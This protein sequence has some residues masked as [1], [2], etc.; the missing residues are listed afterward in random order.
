MNAI[1]TSPGAT[2]YKGETYRLERREIW[3]PSSRTGT[4]V[5]WC[6]EIKSGPGRGDYGGKCGSKR[7]AETTVKRAIRAYAAEEAAKK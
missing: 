6:W 4:R 5:V 7:E 1:I 2:T 3:S